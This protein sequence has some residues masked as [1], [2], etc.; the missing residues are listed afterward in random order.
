MPVVT[1][2]RFTRLATPTN[3][4]GR[5]AIPTSRTWRI[6]ATVNPF[7]AMKFK[8]ILKIGRVKVVISNY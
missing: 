2:W 8:I 7:Q 3:K 4:K 1:N 6:Q 5:G